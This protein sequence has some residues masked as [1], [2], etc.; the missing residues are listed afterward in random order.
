MLLFNNG[1]T[2][3]TLFSLFIF[4]LHPLFGQQ[5]IL[6]ELGS[7]HGNFQ[8]DAKYYQPDSIIGAPKVPEKM[9]SNVFGNINYS[10]GRFSMG[11]RYEA[12][13]DVMQGFDTR[14]KG[15]AV[16]NRWARYKTD[17]LDI[18]VGN[19]YE[20]FGSGIMLRTYY[21][22]GL[23]YD[24]SI[25][26]A[27][28]I[29]SP[30]RGVTLKGV[31]GK[32]RYFFSE[33][34]GIVRGGDAEF[35]ISEILD[36]IIGHKKLRVILGGSFVSKFQTDQ[37]PNLVLPQNVATYG[38]R[39]NIIRG[40]FNFYTEYAYKINDPS[41]DNKY[42]YKDGSAIYS[43]ATY[44][45][46]GLSF[47]IQGKRIDNMSYRSDRGEALTALL[48]NYLPSTT[49]QH[50]YSML[51][52]NPYA[53]QLLGE[54]GLMGEM[55]YKI[56]KG[57]ALGGKYGTEMLGI[58]ITMISLLRSIKSFRKNSKELLCI[59]ISFITATLFSSMPTM[60]AMPVLFRILRW[61]T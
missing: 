34:A 40:G 11:G 35:N 42:S 17:L 2:R 33:G 16:V 39:L 20:Q 13:N 23:L 27:R 60:Q 14:Y 19:I 43:T 1:L 56:K 38:G 25:D 52:L 28:L 61:W 54:V 4:F 53:T 41:A 51:A 3:T 7:V 10:K 48:I 30:I 22:P 5:A 58:C 49:K 59:A 26:G 9:L 21:E 50:T 32:Q 46:K 36:S 44:A 12:Y 45:V 57:T 55:Q 18:T 29:S 47:L 37:D 6:D 15:Q 8:I 24:N 31:I